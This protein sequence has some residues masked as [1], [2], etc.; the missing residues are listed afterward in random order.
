[1]P[2]R[3]F[4]VISKPELGICGGEKK[5]GKAQRRRIIGGIQEGGNKPFAEFLVQ[6]HAVSI[7]EFFVAMCTNRK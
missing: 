3:V 7:L 1:M 5:E 6:L 2:S 4:L